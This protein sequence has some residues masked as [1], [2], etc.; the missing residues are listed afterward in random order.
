MLRLRGKPVGAGNVSLGT[1]TVLRTPNGIP[2]LPARLVAQLARAHRNA[3]IEPIEIVVVSRDFDAA[4]SLQLPWARVVGIIS[5]FAREDVESVGVPAVVGIEGVLDKIDDDALVLL[6]GD[7]GIVL[8]DPDSTALAAYQAE[9]ERI[10]PRRRIF[11][12][13]SHQP[14]VS[15]D[16]REIRVLGRAATLDEVRLALD[17]GAD[18]LYVPAGPPML[19]PES[20][21]EAHLEA[22]LNLA[23]AAAGKPVTIAWDVQAVAAAS[24]LQAARRAEITVAVPLTSTEE[25]S[26]EIQSYLQETREELIGG[27][28]D[29][30]DVRLAGSIE[31][32]ED[33]PDDLGDLVLSRV[34]VAAPPDT[35]FDH[36]ATRTWMEELARRANALLLPIEVDLPGESGADAEQVVNMLALGAA[37]VIVNPAAVGPV[38]EMIRATNLAEIRKRMRDGEIAH[39]DQSR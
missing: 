5:E 22:L 9:R 39:G 34:V 13:Y 14:A 17:N 4:A 32:G 27:D 33:L 21:D 36:E 12:D 23:E 29:F 16:G 24:I 26:G 3:P 19:D 10:A 20:D 25:S 8:V 18:T 35:R 11:L 38:K 31:I 15:L 37:G 7:R 6:D 2:M 28:I 30:S 1:A